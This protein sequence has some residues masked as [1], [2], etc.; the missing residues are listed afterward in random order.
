MLEVTN[1]SGGY[2]KTVILQPSALQVNDGEIVALLGRNGVGKTTL[3]KYVMGLADRF[4][5]S[6]RIN[7]TQVPHV[8]QARAKAGLGYV[9]Q[10]RF[11]FGRLTVEENVAAAAAAFGFPRAQAVEEAMAEFPMLRP[12][13]KALAGTLS[14][15]QQQVLAMARA[16]ATQPRLLMLDEPTE[17]VQPSIV[18]EILAILLRLN[19]ERGLAIFI[20][21][22]DL[23]FC[24]SLATRAY[25]MDRG[26]IVRET[27]R[28]ELAQDRGLLQ[29]LLGV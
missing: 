15:G 27:H 4:S 11:V 12:K 13:A 21:E 5:G 8:P 18:D 6:V 14:G 29:D 23:D 24:M 2:R 26:E 17:G 28:D 3:M 25:V 7:G 10:G 20:A 16:L 9:P 22:Q 1:A 19:R